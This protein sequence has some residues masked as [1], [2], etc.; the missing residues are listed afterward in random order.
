MR[1]VRTAQFVNFEDRF[2]PSVTTG[3]DNMK[4]LYVYICIYIVYLNVQNI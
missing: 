1:E 2:V 4:N 3:T